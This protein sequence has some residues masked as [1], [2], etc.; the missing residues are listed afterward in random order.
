MFSR[1]LLHCATIAMLMSRQPELLVEVEGSAEGFV[2][3]PR[4]IILSETLPRDL[5]QKNSSNAAF[6]SPPSSGIVLGSFALQPSRQIA[7]REKLMI[8]FL[9]WPLGCPAEAFI[10]NITAGRPAS[11]P[12][13]F[14]P[15]FFFTSI[16]FAIIN[17]NGSDS[18]RSQK[19]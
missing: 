7:R 19:V 10:F 16:K 15:S 5:F 4:G 9:W 11:Q 8:L 17:P 12:A 18:L 3:P 14:F 13:S 1:Y 2:C 6:E